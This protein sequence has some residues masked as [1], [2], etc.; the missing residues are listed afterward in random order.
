M[1]NL[2]PQRESKPKKLHKEFKKNLMK[3]NIRHIESILKD[4]PNPTILASWGN[5]I[6]SRKSFKEC[7]EQIYELSKKY[8]SKW[9]EI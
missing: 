7:I 5:N 3:E 1:L 8:N 9:L 6:K 4:I 2:Y